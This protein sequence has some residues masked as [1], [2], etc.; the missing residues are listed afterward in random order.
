MSLLTRSH[1]FEQLT[2]YSTLDEMFTDPE[3]TS[4]TQA[5][6][7]RNP[8]A[9]T[10]AAKLV[11]DCFDLSDNNQELLVRRVSEPCAG[12]A[13]TDV[14][15]AGF[16]DRHKGPVRLF[17]VM[18]LATPKLIQKADTAISAPDQFHLLKRY[19]HADLTDTNHV[20]PFGIGEEPAST[21]LAL[22]IGARRDSLPNN[23][24][25]PTPE[26][27]S[28]LPLIWRAGS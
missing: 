18:G 25:I 11:R 9:S 17:R 2:Q 20:L 1:Q 10:G 5:W 24:V 3:G 22:M 13:F 23:M 12:E 8:S 21:Q 7:F 19:I 27:E 26:L 6:R 28:P 14:V 16:S 4:R 15:F